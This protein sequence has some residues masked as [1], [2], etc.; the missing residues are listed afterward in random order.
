VGERDT[1]LSRPDLTIVSRAPS[2]ASVGQTH[3]PALNT[4]YPDDVECLC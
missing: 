2:P 3:R 1:H 4:R